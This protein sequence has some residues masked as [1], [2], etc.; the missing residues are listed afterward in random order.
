MNWNDLYRQA[1]L[2]DLPWYPGDI[3]ELLRDAIYSGWL[4][5]RTALDIGAGQGTDAIYLATNGYEV[6]CLDLSEA[7]RDIALQ[8]AERAHVDI[9]YIIGD[10]LDMP[11]D[12]NQFDLVLDRGCFEHIA[13]ADRERYAAEVAR[14]LKQGGAYF[15]RSAPGEADGRTPAA[16]LEAVTA[17]FGE[18]FTVVESGTYLAS[19]LGG[20]ASSEQVWIILKQ[21]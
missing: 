8:E 20:R 3:D 6:T 9:E 5:G 13:P 11:L 10:A 14:V 1:K 7:A 18:A 17:A 2:Q 4:R 12:D 16:S 15:Y 21:D 19:G